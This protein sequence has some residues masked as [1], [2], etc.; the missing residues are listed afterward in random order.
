VEADRPAWKRTRRS[1]S[2]T[3]LGQA[4]TGAAVFMLIMKTWFMLGY[5]ARQVEFLIRVGRAGAHHLHGE[6]GT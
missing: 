2:T 6:L 4:R 5:G 1:G 3:S